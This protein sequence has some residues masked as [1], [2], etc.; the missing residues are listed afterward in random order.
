MAGQYLLAID[1]GTTNTKGALFQLD[2]TVRHLVSRRHTVSSP[3]EGWAEHDAEK[4]WWGEVKSICRE[5]VLKEDVDAKEIL[6]IG[7]SALSP[8]MLAVDKGGRA[9]YPAMLYG[10]DRRAVAE[11][12]EL[13]EKYEEGGREKVSLLSTGPKILWLKRHEPEIFEKAAYFIGA[14]SFIV[15]RFT[16]KMVADYACYNINGLPFNSETFDWDDEMCASCGITREKLPQLKWG[17][18]QAG[19]I[20][21]EAAEETGLSEETVVAVGSGDFPAESLS[22]GTVYSSWTKIS[23][24]TTVGVNFGSDHGKM[25][26]S[27]YDY[28]HPKKNI[29]GGAM[30]NGCSTIDWILSMVTDSGNHERPSNTTLQEMADSVPAGSDGL[31]MLPYLNGEKTP[32]FDPDSKGVL[33]GIQCRHTR[34]HLYKASMEAVAYSV[35]HMLEKVPDDRAKEAVVLGGGLKIPGLMQIVSDVTGYRL[36]KLEQLNGSLAGDAFMA[37]M[38]CGVF[39][40]LKEI[41]SWIRTTGVVEPDLSHKLEYDRGYQKYRKLYEATAGLMHE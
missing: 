7:V 21:K 35:R 14:P 6:S 1:I 12:K 32:F 19:T 18:E 3:Q 38:A 9:L 28:R 22:Y 15:N 5:L 37:G 26:F 36:T 29:R 41:N 31:I 25:L 40:E 39:H 13:S 33:F 4:T 16:G 17:T 2:G 23:F 10:L 30:S 34:A 20:T 8:A 11:I 27:D 24:G